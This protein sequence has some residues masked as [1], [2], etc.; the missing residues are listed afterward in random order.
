MLIRSKSD[1]ILVPIPQYPLYSALITL[2]GGTMVPYYLDE[3]RN[4]ALDIKE[5]ET[6]VKKAKDGGLN[7]RSLVVINPGNPTGQV[8]TEQNMHEII[9]LCYDN[10]IL[11]M[12]DE[13]YQKNV[14][15]E[16]SKF[17]SFRKVL[18]EM[19]SPYKDN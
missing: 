17:S 9:Q 6:R 4:W 3:E 5:L 19:G 15:C 1:G 13:V 16:K 10:S 2:Q 12:A 7:V 14:Y 8:L 11:I 18:N